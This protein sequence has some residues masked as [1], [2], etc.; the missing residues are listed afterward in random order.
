VRDGKGELSLKEA[1]G[2]WQVEENTT[3][4]GK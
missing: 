2:A 4:L 1:E 3:H